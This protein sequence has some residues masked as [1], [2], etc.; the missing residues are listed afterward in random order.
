MGVCGPGFCGLLL[1]TETEGQNRTLGS[2]GRRGLEGTPKIFWRGCAAPV[3]DQHFLIMSPFLH[4]FKEFQPQN[5]RFKRN[6]LKTNANLVPKCHFLWGFVK[7]IPLAKEFG[8]KNIPLVE[9]F[10]PKIHPWLRNLGSKSDPWERHTPSKV[11][12]RNLPPGF[13]PAI[14]LCH[15]IV[16]ISTSEN[17]ETNLS[18]KTSKILFWI[19]MPTFRKSCPWPWLSFNL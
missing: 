13:A 11:H 7:T 5:S 4:D 3:F 2:R 9:E 18:T 16:H 6:F 10:L 1:A 17:R 15:N 8:S 19:V 12:I 14:C